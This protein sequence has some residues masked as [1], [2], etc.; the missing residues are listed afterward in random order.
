[1]PGEFIMP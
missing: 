1:M